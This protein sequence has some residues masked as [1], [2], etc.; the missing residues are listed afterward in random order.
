M[1]PRSELLDVVTGEVLP[2][3]TENAHRALST[4]KQMEARLRD[5]KA[6]VTDFL[7]EESQRQGTKT[8][9]TPDGD[10]VLT[11]GV[12]TE[13]DAQTLAQLL[14][15]EGCPEERVDEV[16]VA[17]ISYKVNRSVLRQLTG[18][19]PNYKAA[20][21]LATHEVEKPYRVSVK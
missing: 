15:E 7:I 3:T 13:I 1:A 16:V 2:A 6:V 11:G 10:L 14:R 21:D 4:I 12:G 5:A 17:E 20:A 8:F 9:H 18:A 19:N